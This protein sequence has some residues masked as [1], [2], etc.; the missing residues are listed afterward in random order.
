MDPE[1]GEILGDLQ[2]HAGLF[3]L[4]QN[5]LGDR[6]LDIAVNGV[7]DHFDAEV[8]PDGVPWPRL[9]AD[10]KR[11]K[12]RHFPGQPIGVQE[13]LMRAEIDG[14]RAVGGDSAEWTYGRSEEA[15]QEAGWFQQGDP[16][17]NRPE[18]RF[19]DLN[20]EST[21]RSDQLFDTHFEEGTR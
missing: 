11:W 20:P 2:R 14:E 16:E 13:G 15:R 12:D 18:R 9:Q 1:L 17:Q 4:D 19:A 3:H 7:K 5:G 10:Y 8:N 21:S 6:A